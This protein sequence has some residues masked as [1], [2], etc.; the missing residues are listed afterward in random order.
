MLKSKRYIANLTALFLLFT[1]F[2]TLQAESQCTPTGGCGYQECRRA[3]CITPAVAFATV[4]L[5]AIIAIAVQNSGGT[6]S[7]GHQGCGCN[8]R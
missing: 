5:V 1:P 7:H 3:P 8:N 6:G 2:N 4:A